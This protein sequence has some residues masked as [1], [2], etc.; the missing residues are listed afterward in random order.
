MFKSFV[1]ISTLI[2]L[3]VASGC[4]V[5]VSG[6]GYVD[7]GYNA[8]YDVYGNRCGSYN[9]SPGCNYYADGSKIQDWEDPSYYNRHLEYATWYYTDSYGW[10]RSF[11]G[12]AWLSGSTG[13]LYDE[14]G[15][16]LNELEEGMTGKDLIGDVAALEEASIQEAGRAFAARHALAEETGLHV[17]RTLHDWATLG[18]KHARTDADL[19]DFSQRLFGV[20]LDN[21]KS[22]LDYAKTGD[23]SRLEALNKQVAER[24]G[25]SPETSK[26]ILQSWFRA[27]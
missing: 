20:S 10:S 25:T 6:G 9:P 15:F 1:V 23:L 22:A 26:E 27:Q 13:I 12:W 21:A 3:L 4:S 11:R 5:S 17:A 19:A 7:P 2:A 16:A 14:Y 18:K 24:W 8:W